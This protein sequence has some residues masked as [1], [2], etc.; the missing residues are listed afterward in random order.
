MKLKIARLSLFAAGL[1]IFSAIPYKTLLA[2]TSTNKQSSNIIAYEYPQNFVTN[3][4][5]DCFEQAS[6]HLEAE[7]ARE[8]CDCTLDKF[9]N[10]YNY[11]EYKELSAESKQDI[12]L[13]C[14]EEM[15]PEE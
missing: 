8:V 10:G 4:L 15:E 5:E 14:F 7:D 2:E 12:G 11:K 9:Q 1:L 13:T 3:Y 6:D